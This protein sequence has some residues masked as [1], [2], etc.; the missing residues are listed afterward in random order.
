M[1]TIYNIM[2]ASLYL[3]II[4]VII[5]AFIPCV[6]GKAI[7]MVSRGLSRIADE[8]Y[9]PRWVEV[10]DDKLGKLYEKHIALISSL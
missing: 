4:V 3:L 2:N 5:A 8:D 1:K 9:N 6:I 7:F 10:L